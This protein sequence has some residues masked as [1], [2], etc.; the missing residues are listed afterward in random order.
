[1]PVRITPTPPSGATM[2]ARGLDLLHTK[3]D[4]E[5][6]EIRRSVEAAEYPADPILGEHSRAA[7]MAAA[8]VRR[9]G[10]LAASC[11]GHC[12]DLL[13]D[14][15]L[16]V[17]PEY[18]V[19]LTR[20]AHDIVRANARGRTSDID[21]P[22]GSP[23]DETYRVDLLVISEELAVAWLIEVKR[24]NAETYQRKLRAPLRK[25]EVARLS[26]SSMLKS[27]Y[28]I[29]RVE[30]LLISLYG[31]SRSPEIL[32]RANLDN[33]F[34][35]PIEAELDRLDDHYRTEVAESLQ[36]RLARDAALSHGGISPDE[37]PNGDAMG[38]SQ[39][40]ALPITPAQLFAGRHQPSA[41]PSLVPHRVASFSVGAA[42]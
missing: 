22:D 18:Q 27:A 30:P 12:I 42:R 13:S 31:A 40:E 9:H 37:L 1:M 35:L 20:V 16:E 5:I 21:L 26:A 19:P 25:L 8:Y 10:M 36:A 34:G 32:D 29:S 23:F 24:I 38:R 2:P 28:R 41:V 6:A 39:P 7:S 17:L 11:L 4:A 3:L 33:F 14:G 15:R